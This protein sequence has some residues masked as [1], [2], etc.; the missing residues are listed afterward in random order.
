MRKARM[1]GLSALAAC[2]LLVP[3]SSFGAG[4]ALFEHGARA[5]AMGG[6]FGATADDPTALYF[7]PAGI[8]FQKG[9]S[10]AAGVFF[11][12][13]SSTFSG[14]DPYPGEGYQVKM[15]NQI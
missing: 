13:E 1:I 10:M 15:N 8:A 3:A 2:L 7:N 9:S 6:A 11:I 4:F 5:V 12:T 14:A